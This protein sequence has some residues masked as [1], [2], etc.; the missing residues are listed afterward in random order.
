MPFPLFRRPQLFQSCAK[1]I[2]LIIRA[3]LKAQ[4]TRVPPNLNKW[5]TSKGSGVIIKIEDLVDT[6][7][8]HT[9]VAYQLKMN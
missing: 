3:F 6:S 9:E 2:I 5:L 8:R 7:K 4:I 1:V